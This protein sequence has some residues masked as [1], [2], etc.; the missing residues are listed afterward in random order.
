MSQITLSGKVQSREDFNYFISL[1]FVSGTL[2]GDAIRTSVP[3]KSSSIC[4]G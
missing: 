1:V 2:E 4:S 3:A